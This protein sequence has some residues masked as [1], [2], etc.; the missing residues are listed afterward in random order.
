MI[1]RRIFEFNPVGFYVD[2]GAHHPFRFSNTFYFYKK[3]WNGI[4]IDAMPESMKLFDRFRPRDINL[5]IPIND[6]DQSLTYYS[7]NEPALNSFS[8]D[9]SRERN[10]VNGY[11]IEKKIEMKTSKLSKVLSEYLPVGKKIDFLS[12]DA[13]GFDLNVLKSNDWLKY[14]PKCILIEAQGIFLSEVLNEETSI[15]LQKQN[16]QIIAKTLHSI[17]FMEK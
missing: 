16:Y 3:G 2:V 12:I 15:Y 8:E 13:E 17:F 1:L 4:N 14:R 6:I 7:F 11:F 5:E 9:I 10:G